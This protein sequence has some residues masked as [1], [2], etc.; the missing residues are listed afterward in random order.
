MCPD[1][2][3]RYHGAYNLNSDNHTCR[4]G[5]LRIVSA[6]GKKCLKR[7]MISFNLVLITKCKFTPSL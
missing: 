1:M 4:D 3:G 2:S 7:V 6:E 5:G